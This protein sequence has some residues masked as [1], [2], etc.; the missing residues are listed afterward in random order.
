MER[1]HLFEYGQCDIKLWMRHPLEETCEY[2]VSISGI[3]HFGNFNQAS[4]LGVSSDRWYVYYKTSKYCNRQHIWNCPKI[5]VVLLYFLAMTFLTGTLNKFATNY[6]FS[7]FIWPTYVFDYFHLGVGN[8][9]ECAVKCLLY[10]YEKC[11]F[12]FWSG[13]TCYIAQWGKWPFLRQ[14][15]NGHFGL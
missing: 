8:E 7:S 2:Y 3:C 5:V 14:I 6:Q 15:K 12:Y 9:A 10:D 11:H 4:I 1:L 13:T